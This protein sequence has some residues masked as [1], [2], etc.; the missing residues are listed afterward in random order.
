VTRTRKGQKEN[1]RRVQITR[2]PEERNAVPPSDRRDQRKPKTAIGRFLLKNSQPRLTDLALNDISTGHSPTP[3]YLHE[4]STKS[5]CLHQQRQ[6]KK[7]EQSK[8]T[9][10][11][12]VLHWE[13]KHSDNPKGSETKQPPLGQTTQGE[14]NPGPDSQVYQNQKTRPGGGGERPPPPGRQELSHPSL[15][16]KVSDFLSL[17]Q[18][19]L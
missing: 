7:K 10:P 1:P 12:P 19:R 18:P 4:P 5:L 15:S 9:Q 11:P 14:R 8:N 3:V 17:Q 13:E 2:R 6:N 16:R